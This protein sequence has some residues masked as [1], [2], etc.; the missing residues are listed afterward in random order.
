MRYYVR[1]CLEG[2][3]L[4]LWSDRFVAAVLGRSC[5]LHFMEESSRRRESTEIFELM[6]WTTDPVAIPLRVWLTVLDADR[7]GHASPRVVIHRLRPTE[8]RRGMVYEVLIHVVSVE[9]TRRIGTDGRPLFYPFHFNL[10]V[11]D[12][13][14]EVASAPG[15]REQEAKSTPDPARNRV[16][17]RQSCS[18]E[19]W[20]SNLRVVAERHVPVSP[21]AGRQRAC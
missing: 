5:A 14:Q 3:P 4:H 11:Q 10:G 16:P 1:L 9:D 15:P 17:A 20:R 12:A 7:S 19:Y 21:V 18:A 2:L 8:P 6:V 13:N